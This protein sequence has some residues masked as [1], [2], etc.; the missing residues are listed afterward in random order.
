[1]P[2]DI[3]MTLDKLK[4]AL[5]DAIIVLESLS[6]IFGSDRLHTVTAQV[7]SVKDALGI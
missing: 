2:E 7:I 1:M 5:D 6:V 3:E 4:G